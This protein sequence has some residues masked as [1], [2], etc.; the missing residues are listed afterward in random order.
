MVDAMNHN[1]FKQPT[2]HGFKKNITT[3]EA[4]YSNTN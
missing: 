1:N 4:K 3:I 2:T